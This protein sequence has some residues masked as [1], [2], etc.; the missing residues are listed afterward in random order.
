MQPLASN[1]TTLPALL[2][3]LSL[4]AAGCTRQP[5]HAITAASEATLYVTTY[6]QSQR[7]QPHATTTDT[8]E[9]A[10]IR[11]AIAPGV[12]YQE[13]DGFGYTLTGGSALHLST[14]SAPA[15]ATIL[16]ELFAPPAEGGIGVSYLRLSLGGSDLDEYPWSY[17]DLPAG[18]VDPELRGFSLAYDT[19]YLIPVLREILEIAPRLKLMASPWSPPAWMKD[20]QDT[21]GGSLLP[22]YHEVYARYMAKYIQAMAEE[23]IPIDALTVQNEPLHPGNNPSL[24]MLAG[25]Q[26]E[27]I[28]NNLGPLFRAQ[29]IETKIIVY[30]HNADR[31]DY[32][33]SILDDPAAAA[34]VDGSAFHL[35]GGTIDALSEV[36]DAHPTKHL[37]FTEQWIG[38]PG[39]FATDF[40]WH[41]EN[42]II[43]ATQN[44][45]KTVLEWN[46]AA[47]AQ[48]DPHTD[49]GGCDRCLGAL[50]IT[51]D[52]VVRNPAYYIIAQA[53]KFIPAGSVRVKSS[54]TPFPSVAFRTPA[55][56]IA[57]ILQNNG[58][59]DML[60]E[61]P[62]GNG[63]LRV[64]VP[65]ESVGTLVYSLL[66]T[67]YSPV[68]N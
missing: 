15:R 13:I 12:A 68:G 17:D 10:D 37:Y 57:V 45:S 8:T 30:D 9:P 60:V 23:G 42:L 55:G 29:G 61:L 58:T 22:E 66:S 67:A 38:A 1:P 3:L 54:A 49:R 43:G 4:L 2:V 28:K 51:G 40:A 39:D 47:D 56:D 24:L 25:Q 14:M 46:L 6:D 7:L 35:Y 34:Y 59:T 31:P 62:N 44:W 21:R 33:M 48:Q 5:E 36:H 19:L 63:V 18:A 65:A 41:V 64:K 53:A 52:E 27:F 26:A 20:N 50:T 11:L 32:P 16:N